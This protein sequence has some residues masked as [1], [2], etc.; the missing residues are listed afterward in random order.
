[1]CAHSSTDRSSRP[2]MW[3]SRLPVVV[4]RRAHLDRLRAREP[5]AGALLLVPER[6][7]DAAQVGEEL[8]EPGL[9][10]LGRRASRAVGRLLRADLLRAPLA[11]AAQ[12]G[13]DELPEQRRRPLGP[14]LELRVELGRDE[15]R[16]VVDLDDLDQA[17][18]RR[19]A[20]DHQAGGLEPLAQELLTS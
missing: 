13:V 19:R 15:E 17:L 18:V 1:M 7:R 5:R 14:G 11:R 9:L 12:R 6:A 10:G 20:G 8:R 3:A 2:A 16:V 4:G